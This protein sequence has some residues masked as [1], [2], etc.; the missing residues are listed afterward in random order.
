MQVLAAMFK[1]RNEKGGGQG[2]LQKLKVIYYQCSF[3]Y[4][5]R[6]KADRGL[7]RQLSSSNR[8]LP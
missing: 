4:G 2:V 6:V 3:F 1:E 8:N 7:K 5:N